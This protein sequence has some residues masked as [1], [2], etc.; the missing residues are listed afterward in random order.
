[1][2]SFYHDLYIAQFKGQLHLIPELTSG[3]LDV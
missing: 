2:K 3:L 1:M